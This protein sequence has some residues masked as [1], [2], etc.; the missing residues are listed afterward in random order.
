MKQKGIST[1]GMIM[2]FADK[3]IKRLIALEKWDI[4]DKQAQKHT[5]IKTRKG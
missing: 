1:K 2:D 5:H 3:A 4:N